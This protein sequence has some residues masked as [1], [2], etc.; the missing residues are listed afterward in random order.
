M[1]PAISVGG[2][3]ARGSDTAARPHRPSRIRTSAGCNLC[4][5]SGQ[6]RARIALGLI[7]DSHIRIRLPAEMTGHRRTYEWGVRPETADASASLSNERCKAGAGPRF[8]QKA[9]SSAARRGTLNTMS[10]SHNP[11]LLKSLEPRPGLEPGTCRLR[12]GCST[13]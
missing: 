5:T 1:V 11:R 13:N 8:P 3:A 7:A 6:V 2:S 12:I 9:S 10:N 4:R